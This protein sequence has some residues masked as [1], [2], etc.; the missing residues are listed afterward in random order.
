VQIKFAEDLRADVKVWVNPDA[1]SKAGM[2][3]ARKAAATETPEPAE[4]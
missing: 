3:A 4:A 1:E 2:E